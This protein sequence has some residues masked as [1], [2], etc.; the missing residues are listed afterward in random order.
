[1]DEIDSHLELHLPPLRPDWEAVVD[2][3]IVDQVVKLFIVIAFE[4]EAN[5]FCPECG[6]PVDKSQSQ[7][8][9]GELQALA[10]QHLADKHP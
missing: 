9:I 5:L 3:A 7:Y 6:D 2:K 10:A 1:M 8:T 4:Q